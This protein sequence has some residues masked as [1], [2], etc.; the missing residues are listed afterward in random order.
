MKHLLKAHKK[1]T[2][3]K[4]LKG[5]SAY[6][7]SFNFP[8]KEPPHKD[9]GWDLARHLQSP[10]PRNP[11]KSQKNVLRGVWEPPTLDPH[12][13]FCDFVDF[14]RNFLGVRGQGVPNSSR[15]TF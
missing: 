6:L 14:F 15:E 5:S 3:H 9:W 2:P 1:N 10:K 13:L 11:E 7:F 4:E 8:Q 12:Q